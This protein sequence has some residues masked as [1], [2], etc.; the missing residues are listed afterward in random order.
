MGLSGEDF[1]ENPN[2]VS[3]VD[4]DELDYPSDEELMFGTPTELI[5]LDLVFDS[6]N[7]ETEELDSPDD[8]ASNCDEDEFYTS[9]SDNEVE[10][11]GFG[12]K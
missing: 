4:D 11:M 10:F 5:N 3:Y 6:D 8:E 2:R 1:I 12:S 7:E 9:S